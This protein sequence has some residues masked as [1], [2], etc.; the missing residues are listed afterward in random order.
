[1]VDRENPSRSGARL[2]LLI[3]AGCVGY[4]LAVAFVP[5]FTSWSPVGC[6]S[7]RVL[8]LHC[9]TCGL[10]RAMA[11]VVHLDVA[12]A[13]RYNP[14]VLI[15]APWAIVFTMSVVAHAAGVKAQPPLSS[16][17]QRCAWGFAFLAL[18][19]LFVVRTTTWIAPALNPDGWLVPPSTFPP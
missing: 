4:V 14:L 8:G 13:I 11:C 19:V 17:A 2:N 5:G 9:P 3:V 1:M 16:G 7:H 12:A 18:A 6:P 15:V 10:T